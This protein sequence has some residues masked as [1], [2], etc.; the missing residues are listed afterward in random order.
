MCFHGSIIFLNYFSISSNGNGSTPRNTLIR[1]RIFI[2]KSC[3]CCISSTLSHYWFVCIR[4]VFLSSSFSNVFTT[5]FLVSCTT[6]C[7]FLLLPSYSVYCECTSIWLFHTLSVKKKKQ[8]QKHKICFIQQKSFTLAIIMHFIAVVFSQFNCKTLAHSY[9][10][11]FNVLKVISTN[12][13][14]F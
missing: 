8:K 9:T 6:S 10:K 11:S 5:Y 4:N 12:S 1:F 7:Q 14:F 2:I 3:L 13:H